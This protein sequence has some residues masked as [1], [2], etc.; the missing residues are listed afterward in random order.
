MAQAQVGYRPQRGAMTLRAVLLVFT[1]GLILLLLV[2]SVT[3]SY[4][5]FRNYLSGQLH[6]HA[7]DAAT[8]IG[9]S[10]S[11]AIDGRD[12]VAAASLID[13]VFDSGR[14]L[15][16]EYLG[17][18]ERPVAGRQLPLREVPAPDWFVELARLPLPVGEAE[19]VRGWQRLGR[20]QVISHPAMAY[21]DLWRVTLGILAGTALIGGLGLVALFILLS[22][23]LRPLRELEVQAEEVGH[24]NFRRRVR[25]N[26]TRELNRVTRAMNQM[27]DDLGV[28]FDGQV[29]LIQH[30]RRVNNE[31]P[32]TG[33]HSRMAF[34]QR[35]KVEVET[36]E[37]GYG[38]ALLLFQLAAFQ[39]Y[40][41]RA[42]SAAA[43]QLLQR[44]AGVI[45]QFARAHHGAFAGRRKGA[46]FAVFIPGVSFADGLFW[47]KQ[48]LAE[49]DGVYGD[50]AR[51]VNAAVHGGVTQVVPG[52]RAVDLLAEADTVL[53]QACDRGESNC[54]GSDAGTGPHH[55]AETWRRIIHGALASGAVSLWQ[56]PVIAAGHERTVHH[57]VFARIRHDGR[58]IKA[59]IFQPMAERLGL[60]AQLDLQ[61]ARQALDHLT[62]HPRARLAMSLGYTTVADNAFRTELLAML[63]A[64]GYARRRMWV[65]VAEQTVHHHRTAVSLLVRALHRLQ[66]KV[67][68]DRFG[69]GGVP[70]SYLKDLP[71]QALRIDSS[72]IH[73]IDSREDSRFYLESVVGIAHS[74][75]VRVFVSGVETAEEW[76][77]VRTTGVDG[78]MGYHLGRPQ[79]L[80]G[81]AAGHAGER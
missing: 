31:D 52:G 6:G 70:F 33:L 44:V 45:D 77:V 13:A 30:L 81:G 49:L 62:T 43:D 26:S 21:R 65:G 60:T 2:A 15:S 7:Q 78:G 19:V 55:D 25:L 39:E 69:V 5:S 76:T 54:V 17:L 56:Q 1:G 14:Y 63:A 72:F 24:R 9:L 38:G 4:G 68:V 20:V 53:R 50:A 74:R 71:F 46:E 59:G 61:V 27:V 73:D 8:A 36:E 42:G 12:A 11:N 10:L 34:E 3:V 40:N 37:R 32:V 22:H 35:L 57:Y 66:V 64:A 41:Q 28:L 18:D 51:S 80:T 67:M 75:G 48:L 47:A 29:Q 16:V 23:T 79:P 58:W